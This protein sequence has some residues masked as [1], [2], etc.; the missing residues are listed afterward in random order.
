VAVGVALVC[1]GCA[2]GNVERAG[3]HRYAVPEGYRISGRARPV[4]L[5]LSEQDG[6]NFVLNPRAALPE[7]IIVGVD[8]KWNIC[9]R[10]AGSQAYVNTT[11]CGATPTRWRDGQLRRFGD[12][13][14]WNYAL[15]EPGAENDKPK[16]IA[17]SCSQVSGPAKGLCIAPLPFGDLVLTLNINDK[18][19]PKL[20][21][22]YDAATA[23]LRR[24]E[25]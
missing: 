14:F 25:R 5:P 24:W 8:T 2:G 10:A 6:F 1:S 7:Q 3:N 22:N 21:A 12:E 20:A 23:L 16:A 11:I 17:V 19:I 18:D 15:A 9:R 13:T 4:F